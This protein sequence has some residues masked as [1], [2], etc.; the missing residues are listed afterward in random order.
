M[1]REQEIK[2]RLNF[3]RYEIASLKYQI[4]ESILHNYDRELLYELQFNLVQYEKEYN[5]LYYP[6]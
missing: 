3:L 2:Y 5:K 6:I 1:N 4:R